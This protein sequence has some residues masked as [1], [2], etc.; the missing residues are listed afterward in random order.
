ML[1]SPYL[2]MIYLVIGNTVDS[3]SPSTQCT[4]DRTCCSQYLTFKSQNPC[5]FATVGHGISGA[6]TPPRS[7]VAVTVLWWASASAPKC[8]ALSWKWYFLHNTVWPQCPCW[9]NRIFLM[10]AQCPRRMGFHAERKPSF[11]APSCSFRG[12]SACKLKASYIV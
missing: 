9:E 5:S 6:K 12:I 11:S 4:I 10:R 1:P 8:Q 7:P 3:D 2:L